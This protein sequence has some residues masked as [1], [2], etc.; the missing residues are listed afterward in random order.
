MF[1]RGSFVPFTIIGGCSTNKP[2]QINLSKLVRQPVST[3]GSGGEERLAESITLN[4]AKVSLDY[5]PQDD[6]GHPEQNLVTILRNSV[7][8]LLVS[9]GISIILATAGIDIAVGG[10]LGICAIL[11]GGHYATGGDFLIAAL[12]SAGIQVTINQA[13]RR[14]NRSRSSSANFRSTAW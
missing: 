14:Q 1:R 7:E 11:L 6:K 2:M 3:G 8:L 9:L 12:G 5:L 10:A 13:T 4:F